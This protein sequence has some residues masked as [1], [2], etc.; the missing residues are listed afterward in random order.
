MDREALR[1]HILE[2][3]KQ[4]TSASHSASPQVVANDAVPIRAKAPSQA[5]AFAAFAPRVGVKWDGDFLFIESSGIPSH[6]MMVG[7]T[8]W[9]QQVPLPQSYYGN[10]AWRIPLH[11]VPAQTPASIEGH[12]L[13]GAIALAV[14]GIPIFNP[15]NNRGE[16]SQEIGELDQW[17][18]H[19][20]RADDYHYHAA[21]LHLQ[22]M[23]G[24]GMP[25]AYALD[26]YPIYGLTEPDG[27]PLRALDVCQGHEDAEYGY[28]YHASTKRPY[29]QSAFHG[30]VRE[31][32]GQVEPQPRAQGMRPALT[33]LRGAEIT[34]FNGTPDGK[35]Y[36]LHYTLNKAKAEIRYA[37]DGAGGWKF[38]YIATDGAVTEEA[39]RAGSPPPRG[40]ERERRDASQSMPAP[41]MYAQASLPGTGE[42]S[43]DTKP[44]AKAGE[45][46]VN[47]EKFM[48][49]SPAIGADGILPRDYSGDGSGVTLPLEWK[50]AP[51]GTREYAILMDHRDPEGV[52][53]W[54]WILYN[55][56]GTITTLPKNVQG[57]GTLGTSFKGHI[58]YEAPHSKGPG[59]KTYVI[60]VHA[61]SASLKMEVDPSAVNREVLLAAMKGKVL[62][63]AELKVTYT[64]AGGSA[65]DSRDRPPPRPAGDGERRPPPR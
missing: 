43:R 40:R 54:Y 31:A 46:S 23:A 57:I 35:G 32:G 8:N 62:G 16:I 11:P 6:G 12:F 34:A 50:G 19:C 9:Q 42:V 13:R 53:K 45:S 55:I 38:Q 59:Q 20:G 5:A 10:N 56:P 36:V 22:S 47:V 2:E 41:R 15:Q 61:L 64:S 58:G 21:P 26:G 60:T 28:H 4:K 39:Y 29:L 65:A 33:P 1:A 3:W 17:G 14:N 30:V 18:G 37:S 52:M 7:I 44:G 24:K 49:T 25:I 51:E 63:S 27:S 48:L